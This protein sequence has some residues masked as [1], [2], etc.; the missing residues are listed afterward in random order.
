[1]P[2]DS[3][4][5]HPLAIFKPIL[6]G[7]DDDQAEQCFRTALKTAAAQSALSLELRAA[8]SLGR[9]SRDTGRAADAREC[10]ANTLERFTEGFEAADLLEANSILKDLE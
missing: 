4:A 5:T 7:G 3:P 2:D 9:F 10:L 1:M 6:S 8:N